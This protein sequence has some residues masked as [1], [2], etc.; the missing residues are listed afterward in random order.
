MFENENVEIK[1]FTLKGTVSRDFR[2]LVFSP[3]I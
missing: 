1:V 2:L 3:S